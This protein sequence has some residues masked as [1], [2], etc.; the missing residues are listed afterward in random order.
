MTNVY[1][2]FRN[3]YLLFSKGKYRDEW[4]FQ[5]LMRLEWVVRR[6][7]KCPRPWRRF[8]GKRKFSSRK[9]R[10]RIGRAHCEWNLAHMQKIIYINRPNIISIWHSTVFMRYCYEHST[11]KV[12]ELTSWFH[13]QNF[14]TGNK[15]LEC[16]FIRWNW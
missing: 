3:S 14:I 13:L 10:S 6:E 15:K 12:V 11:F 9:G 2:T 16:I 5:Y 4:C 1:D 7:I 8:P